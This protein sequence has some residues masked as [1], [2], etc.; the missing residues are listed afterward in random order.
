MSNNLLERLSKIGL[1][2]EQLADSKVYH[3]RDLIDTEIPI[4]NVAL[5]GEFDSGLG[6]G[7]IVLA[8]PSKHFKSNTGIL[9]VAAFLRKHKDGICLFYDSEFGSPPTYWS[10]FGIDVS[11]VLHVPIQ[12]IE[13]MKQDMPQKLNDISD[14]D[15]VI[16][17]VD[18]I[19]NLA[20][21][22]EATDVLEG[23]S[24]V[25]MTRAR[26]MKSFFRIVTPQIKLR[27][28]PA[29]FVAH[30]YQTMEMF[31]KAVVSGG[32]GIYYSADIIIIF[33]RQQ[34]KEGT[35]VTGFNFILNI[36]KSRFVKEKSK[37]PLTVLYDSGINKWSGLLDI[38]LE[39]GHVIK[40]KNGWYAMVD[41]DTG[42]VSGNVRFDATQT[43]DFLGKVLQSPSFVE[44]VKNKYL[45][46]GI[47]NPSDVSEDVYSEDEIE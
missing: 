17:F 6:S 3:K 27:N 12:N 1:K 13:E 8:G 25:D 21:K 5:G 33:G 28:I 47:S 11:R 43:E 45:L 44:Y 39:S 31:S 41:K 16:I 15:K 20:S 14:K 22:K 46:G 37:I 34:E 9:M 30:T 42:E 26:E 19:G 10:N 18:S 29:I 40:P 36:E 38:A 23:K 24:T 35:V 7:V 2:S 32:T 4:L